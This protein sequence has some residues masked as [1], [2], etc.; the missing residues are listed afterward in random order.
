MDDLVPA[1]DAATH[2]DRIGASCRAERDIT[3][4]YKYFFYDWIRVL[5]VC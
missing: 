4:A 2:P 3:L 1:L 5:M